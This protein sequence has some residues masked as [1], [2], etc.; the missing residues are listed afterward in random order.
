MLHCIVLFVSVVL[1]PVVI[2]QTK[3]PFVRYC[4]VLDSYDFTFFKSA[5]ISIKMYLSLC[6]V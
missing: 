5:V 1:T 6:S 3:I 4:K 2:I